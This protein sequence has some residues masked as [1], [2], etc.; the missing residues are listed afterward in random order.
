MLTVAAAMLVA[1]TSLSGA[2]GAAGAATG[3]GPGPNTRVQVP[4]GVAQGALARGHVFGTTPA[5]TPETVSF[6]L[7]AR[8]LAA[9][10]ARVQAGQGPQLSVAQFAGHYG[11]TAATIAALRSYLA[12][13]GITTTPYPD[14]LDVSATG[15]AGQ[16]DQALS[17]QQHNYSVPP[18][19]GPGGQ[20]GLPA[21]Q[22][23]GTTQSPM[24]PYRLA[25]HVLSILGLTNYSAFTDDLARPSH[26]LP[27]HAD[28]AEVT[29]AGAV[30]T[31]NRTPADF[32][33]DYGL[34]PLYRQ[35]ATGR[36]QTI[37]IVAPAGL[38]ADV[39]Y[40]YWQQVLHLRV[41]AHRLT[42]DQIDGGAGAPSEQA[43][44]DESY[45]DVEQAGGVAPQARIVAYA[46]PSTDSGI[47]DA[48][49][50]AASQ[51]QAGSVS[52]SFQESETGLIDDVATGQ[53]SPAYQQAMDQAYLEMAAQGQTAFTSAGDAGAYDATRDVGS[54]NLSI[55][56]L[57][58]SPYV[59]AAGGTTLAG[60]AQIQL[61][62]P[63]TL[64][65]HIPAQRTWGW[66]YLWPL[67]Q[68]A[69]PGHSEAQ[70]AESFVKGGGGGFS[71]I[72]PMPAYQRGL[73]AFRAVPYLTPSDPQTQ[74]GLTLPSGWIF[75]AHPAV[76]SGYGAG[77]ATPD[78]A[79]DADPYTG[80]LLYDPLESPA[81]SAG[82]GGTSYVAPQ[83]AG[84]AAVIN[85]AVG[86]RTGF[87]NPALYRFA[88]GPRSP[89]RPL[90]TSGTSND[91]LY[92]TGTP[93]QIFNPGSGLGVPDLAALAADF[94]RR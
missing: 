72:E 16:F 32:A 35:G 69:F 46:A 51:N 13:F 68:R 57:S 10:Q 20:P 73:G 87:W 55:G 79:A 52:S 26:P 18:R 81:L 71:Q 37:G 63:G 33:R 17:V 93:G 42:I 5:S 85:Q 34:D 89:F 65:A 47:A 3:S 12:A 83:L 21:Q 7:K 1:A 29:Q 62:G 74:D 53:E 58:G 28:A 30:H 91:N 82:N 60:A 78:L 84:A 8:D 23:H 36:D 70:F 27:G 14:G 90:G 94:G 11:Q 77:R 41:P 66:D 40:H 92:Y 88:R 39:P 48:F 43:G 31:G 86:G 80:Y 24:L 2:A 75:N 76:I 56:N 19:P 22:V 54:T 67:L 4:Q 44:S 50:T 64:T 6:I 45:L 59:T 15:T 38:D 25:Q 49:F 9:L 61:G